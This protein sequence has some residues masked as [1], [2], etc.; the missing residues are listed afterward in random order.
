[1]LESLQGV[2]VE[3]VDSVAY[4]VWRKWQATCGKTAEGVDPPGAA[5]HNEYVLVKKIHRTI[6]S[7]NRLAIHPPATNASLVVQS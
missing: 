2:H 5:L 4:R 3:C 7:Q 6:F 1:M